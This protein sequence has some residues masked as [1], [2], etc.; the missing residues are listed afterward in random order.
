MFCDTA[1]GC[2][3]AQLHKCYDLALLDFNCS[4]KRSPYLNQVTSFRHGFKTDAK[5]SGVGPDISQPHLG[6][7]GRA[8]VSAPRLK[9]M[10]IYF[11]GRDACA[12]SFPQDMG[13]PLVMQKQQLHK[14]TVSLTCVFE[15]MNR[16]TSGEKRKCSLTT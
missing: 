15:I 10:G 14:C 13:S 16:W 8:N 5:S 11:L 9:G 6:R 1:V 3:S 2:D 12:E 4:V 7:N